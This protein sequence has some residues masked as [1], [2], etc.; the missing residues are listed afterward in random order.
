MV[1]DGV[2]EGVVGSV[3]RELMSDVGNRAKRMMVLERRNG[4]SKRIFEDCI[5]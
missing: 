3:E 5:D 4:V 1:V 2:D